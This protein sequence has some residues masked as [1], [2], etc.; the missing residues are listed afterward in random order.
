MKPKAVFVG[1]LSLIFLY[2][3][4]SE[5]YSQNN[6]REL[7][8]SHNYG[9]KPP[10]NIPVQFLAEF[11]KTNHRTHSSPTFSPDNN[12]VYWSVFLR[13]SESKHKNE[14]I[15]V[16]KKVNNIWSSPKVA[17]FSGEYWDGGPFFSKDSNKGVR[18]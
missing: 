6:D 5:T 4:Y 3:F 17:S 13:T 10:H 1:V 8:L 12:E 16:S 7:M 14:T 9:Q 2:G 18:S 11:I 15:L